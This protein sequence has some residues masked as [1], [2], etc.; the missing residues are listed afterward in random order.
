[1]VGKRIALIRKNKSWT[2]KDLAEAT[3]LSRGYIAAIEE[4]GSPGVKTVAMIAKALGVD[5]RE[6][7][8]EEE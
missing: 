8:E 7:L 1:M 5:A 3:R 2:Q 6:L 4:G